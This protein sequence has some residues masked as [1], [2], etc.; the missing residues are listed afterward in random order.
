M[1]KAKTKPKYA[2]LREAYAIVGGIPEHAFWMNSILER[3]GVSLSCGTVACALGWL[4][5][6]PKFQA[7]TG[8]ATVSRTSLNSSGSTT[9]KNKPMWYDVAAADVFGITMNEAAQLYDV[10]AADVFGITMNEAAQLFGVAKHDELKRWGTHKEVFLARV[11]NFLGTRGQLTAQ[12]KA[13][14][15]AKLVAA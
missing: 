11:R 7:K 13:A 4:G 1:T 3:K 8:L 10:A 2:L 12:L 6:H 15:A 9:F 14:K 5:M